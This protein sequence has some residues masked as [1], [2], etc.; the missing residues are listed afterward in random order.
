MD[1]TLNQLKHK[2]H[3]Q[4]IRADELVVRQGLAPTKTRAQTLIL[5]G[6]VRVGESRIDK[7]GTLVSE[8]AALWIKE[9]DHPY[10]SRGGVKLAGAL[11]DLKINVSGLHCLDVGASTGGFTDCL[12]QRGASSVIAVDVGYGQLAQKL[13]V[14]PRVTIHERTNARYLS[15]VQ[16][17]KQVDLTVVDASFIS[18]QK[19]GTA[20]ASCTRIGG[21]LVALIKP[22]FEVGREEASRQ[23]GVIRDPLIREDAISRTKSAMIAYGFHSLSLVPSMLPGPKG[24]REVFFYARRIDAPLPTFLSSSR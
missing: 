23:K 3:N 8:Q 24:N 9:Q 15:H 11:D 12:L 19:L 1:A 6:V 22:Q 17:G 2:K 14:D 16:L 5:S 10:V 18:L 7:A 21:Y 20:L 13:R 4:R